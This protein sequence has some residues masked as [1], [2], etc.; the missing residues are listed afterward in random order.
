VLAALDEELEYLFDLEYEWSG[1]QPM[2]DGVNYRIGR[3]PDGTTIVAATVNSMGM[4]ET[5]IITSKLIR[6]WSPRLVGMIGLC[7]GRKEKGVNIGDIIVPTQ[8]FH[9]QFGAFKEGRIL[10]ELRVENSDQQLLGI[11]S[12][13]SKSDVLTTIRKGLPL[14]FPKPG[15]ELRCLLGPMASA[16]LVVKDANKLQEAVDA[17]RKTI[18][19]EMERYAFMKAAALARARWAVVAKS[20]SDYADADKSDDFREYAKRTST[21]F[22]IEIA[23]AM[24]STGLIDSTA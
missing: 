15:T 2:G 24:T 20:V 1:P 16:D 5:A 3:M 17:D 9:Y 18:A 14:G 22:F 12:Y 4:V 23:Q 19:I 11:V 21:Y 13:L 6:T 10:K 8:T 7:G